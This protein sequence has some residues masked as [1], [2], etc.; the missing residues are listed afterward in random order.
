MGRHLVPL[1]AGAPGL[2]RIRVVDPHANAA[3]EEL[4]YSVRDVRPLDHS[5]STLSSAFPFASS[6]TSLSR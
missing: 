5:R 6:S 2:S 3:D 4:G 1:V